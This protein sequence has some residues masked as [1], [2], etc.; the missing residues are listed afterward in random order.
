MASE[1]TTGSNNRRQLNYLVT[2]IVVAGIWAYPGTANAAEWTI[3]PYLWA[4]DVKLDLDVNG[5]PALG[6][7]ISFNDLVD[8]LDTAFMGHFEGRGEKWG[9]FF[10]AIYIDLSDT[11][12][13]P[14]GPGG[15]VLG[16]RIVDSSMTLGLYELGGLYRMGERA[17]GTAEFD[18]LFGIRQVDVEQVFD[19]VLAGPGG[20]MITESLD[21]SETDAFVGG[22]VLGLFNEKWG[23]NVRADL[24]GGG[25]DG[26]F[27]LFG[28][29]SYTFGQ[30]GL[31]SLDL[32]YRYTT[33]KL[34]SDIDGTPVD[35]DITMSGP[36]LGFIF[37]F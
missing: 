21:V 28:G 31:F 36:I 1:R 32:G 18:L 4:S 30:T 37:D 29:I 20:T 15:P 26:V 23:Y 6:A 35:T 14:I 27:N 5:D 22:R 25:T 10:D 19:I 2:L 24:G 34:S 13:T 17:P 8:K 9:G 7:D 33:I 11:K 3:A 16:D 12:T